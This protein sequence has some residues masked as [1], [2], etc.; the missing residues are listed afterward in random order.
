MAGVA[1]LGGHDVATR[2]G[3]FYIFLKND[4]HDSLLNSFRKPFDSKPGA[5]KVAATGWPADRVGY[6]SLRER[7]AS[8]GGPYIST[9][10]GLRWRGAPGRLRRCLRTATGRC[11]SRA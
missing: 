7:P 3:F 5:R 1:G 11:F 10:W 4:L 6:A 2:G 8:G 9:P